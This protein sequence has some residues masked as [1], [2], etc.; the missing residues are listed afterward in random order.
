[1][2]TAVARGAIQ[3]PA[4]VR[5]AGR[6]PAQIRTIPDLI[7]YCEEEFNAEPVILEIDQDT[8]QSQYFAAKAHVLYVP[9]NEDALDLRDKPAKV[10]VW[11]A[12]KG[13]D[14]KIGRRLG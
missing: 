7:E 9:K 5:I 10:F 4:D 1:M 2:V 14:E 3:I 8:L 6:I 13:G 11:L 12:E